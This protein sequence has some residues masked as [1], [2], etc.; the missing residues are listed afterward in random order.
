MAR[1]G[2]ERFRQESQDGG[3]AREMIHDD[4]FA[5]R[6][7]D[8][9]RFLDQLHGI[10]NDGDD[11]ERHDVIEAVVGKFEIQGVHFLNPDMVPFVLEDLILRAREHVGREIDADDLA[12]ARICRKRRAGAGK[13]VVVNHFTSTS[14]V[15]GFLTE[16]LDPVTRHLGWSTKL[17]MKP[18]IEETNL[19][20]DEVYKLS[21]LSLHSVLIGTND[22]NGLH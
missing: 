5:G 7:A 18:F 17:K 22:K 15:L 16:A 13:I 2:V 6:L 4:D 19:K 20:I 11:V 12:V 21:K 8:P 10:G 1:D 9:L 14:P 3:R